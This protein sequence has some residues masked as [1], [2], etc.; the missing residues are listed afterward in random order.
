MQSSAP[1]PSAGSVQPLEPV[2]MN[3][4]GAFGLLKYSTA[5]VL[6]NIKPYLGILGLSILAAI[7]GNIADGKDGQATSLQGVVVTILVNL[8]SILLSAAITLVIIAGVK[9]QKISIDGSLRQGLSFFV[10][11]FA[12]SLLKGLISV[13]SFVL[14][15][16]PAFF[17]IPRLALAEYYL[18]DGKL[19]V[20]EAL[21]ASWEAT[22]GNVGKVWGIF[23]ASVVF[24]LI[25]LTIIGIPVAIYL[26]IMYSDAYALLY[27][28]LLKQQPATPMPDAPKAPT[29]PA[30]G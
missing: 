20:I 17:I 2:P 11:Y 7:A 1:Q 16:V 19:D 22:R 30:A 9:R 23:G 3:W 28:S 15:V 24:A 18:L 27:F 25:F 6:H 13:V 8:F 5:A 12:L 10:S 26:S 21:K 4:P 29:R 14:L